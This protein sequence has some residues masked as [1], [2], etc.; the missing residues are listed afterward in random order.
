M[1]Y[2]PSTIQVGSGH[3]HR[4]QTVLPLTC[5]ETKCGHCR[6]QDAGAEDVWESCQWAV[7]RPSS[8]HRESG[9]GP[10]LSLQLWGLS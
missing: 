3:K 7:V 6:R 10:P 4:E 1:R 5:E 2:L 8:Y 9:N